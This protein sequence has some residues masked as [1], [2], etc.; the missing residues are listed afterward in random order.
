[1]RGICKNCEHSS[2]NEEGRICTKGLLFVND[3]DFCDE[4]ENNAIFD[5]SGIIAFTV[6]AIGI[7]ILLAKFL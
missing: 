4:F 7:V 2:N 1:M 6:V 3:N 5:P